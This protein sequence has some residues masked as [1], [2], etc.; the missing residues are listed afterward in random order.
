MLTSPEHAPTRHSE[1][2]TTFKPQARNLSQ[3]S[4]SHSLLSFSVYLIFSLLSLLAS[5]VH[6]TRCVC[7]WLPSIPFLRRQAKHR[8]SSSGR[9]RKKVYFQRDRQQGRA[10]R[11]RHRATEAQRLREKERGTH[12][13]TE[14]ETN[15]ERG[16]ERGERI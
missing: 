8:L 10:N 1:R 11:H 9:S 5:C 6:P 16:W 15:M 4:S 3:Y 12:T 7:P 14:N 2:H 13:H